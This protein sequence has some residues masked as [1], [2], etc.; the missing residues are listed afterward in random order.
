MENL[1]D[2]TPHHILQMVRINGTMPIYL[3]ND[4]VGNTMANWDI[5]AT[6]ELLK[7]YY[8]QIQKEFI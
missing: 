2:V 5:N 6:I 8:H 4:K 3:G 1:Y 7:K